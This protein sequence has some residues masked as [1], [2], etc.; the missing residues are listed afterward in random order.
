MTNFDKQYQ[1]QHGISSD[2]KLSGGD[3]LKVEEG[4]EAI[5]RA[6]EK[7]QQQD[8]VQGGTQCNS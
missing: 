8:T 6:L 3:R 4:K 2:A 5:R 1:E 7:E